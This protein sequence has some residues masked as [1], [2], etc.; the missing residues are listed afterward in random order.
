MVQLHISM[1]VVSFARLSSHD[2]GTYYQTSPVKSDNF[3][4]IYLSDLH[5]QVSDSFGLRLDMQTRPPA[6]AFYLLPVRQ[7]ETLPLTS[8]RFHLPVDTLVFS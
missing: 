2:G 5:L 7:T 1:Q 6:S 3:H 8:F 4:L